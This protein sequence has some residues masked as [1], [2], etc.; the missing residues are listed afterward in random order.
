MRVRLF[1]SSTWNT[2]LPPSRGTRHTGTFRRR[3]E[4]RWQDSRPRLFLGWRTHD[5]GG[6]EGRHAPTYQRPGQRLCGL[7]AAAT[8]AVGIYHYADPE[9]AYLDGVELASVNQPRLGADWAGLCA[10][11]VSVALSLN[12][13][14]VQVIEAVL[15]IAHRNNSDLF[16]K[17]N[18]ALSSAIR[19]AQKYFVLLVSA[20]PASWLDALVGGHPVSAIIGGAILG[21]LRGISV[22]PSDWRGRAEPVTREWQPIIDVVHARQVKER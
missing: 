22:F 15:K 2:G 19:L 18:P 12:P 4:S 21:A 9:Y 14:L 3:S 8:P 5:P 16:Y 10:A 1:R 17:L 7:I 11:A 6:I 13:T 20:P